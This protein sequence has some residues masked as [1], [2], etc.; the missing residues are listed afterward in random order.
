[1]ERGRF[2]EAEQII[3]GALDD[4]RV[5]ANSLPILLGPSYCHQG[6]Q[7]ETL[8]L[9]ETRWEALN[10][11]GEGDSEL[12]INLVRAH[13]DLQQRP[14][15]IEV[16]RSV[17]DQA[18][19]LAPDDD[20]IWLGKANLAIRVGSYEEAKRWIDECLRRRPEDIPIW[21]ARLDWAVATNQVLAANEALKHLP[22]VGSTPAE[23]LRL[24]AWLATRRGDRDAERQALERLIAV[25]HADLAALER[26]A[27]LAVQDGQPARAGELRTRIGE[28][29]QLEARYMKLYQRNQPRRDA[30]EMAN[31]AEQLGQV[32]E[33][34]AFL[35]VGTAV[36]PDRE[37]L[38][39]R[40]DKLERSE[41]P[42]D[43]K[44]RFLADVLATQSE[45]ATNSSASSPSPAAGQAPSGA[46][47]PSPRVPGRG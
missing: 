33:A 22:V 28:I 46:S 41:P 8:R 30:V 34:K 21:R 2:S 47:I 43:P 35:T 18:A 14:I 13:L 17:L 25:D 23:V 27:E 4:P 26:L 36:H 38:R 16:I 6:R 32:F 5:N 19:S 3:R 39:L 42:R 11:A 20:R 10:Q 24:A 44:G 12:A 15:P 45:S 1:M 29:H 9:I 7:E 31:L 37:D 40:L